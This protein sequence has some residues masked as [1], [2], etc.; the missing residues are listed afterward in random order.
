MSYCKKSLNKHDSCPNCGLISFSFDE[1]GNFIEKYCPNCGSEI[2]PL[3]IEI[4]EN[5]L[6]LELNYEQ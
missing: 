4:L 2:K 5:Q 3:P 6:S 1:F